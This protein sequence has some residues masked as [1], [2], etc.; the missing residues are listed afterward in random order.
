MGPNWHL[1]SA[2]QMLWVR[3]DSQPGCPCFWGRRNAKRECPGLH[4]GCPTGSPRELYLLE[5][6]P[7]L[8][9]CTSPARALPRWA[10]AFLSVRWA[11]C[12]PF[13][14][15]QITGEGRHGHPAMQEGPRVRKVP[16]CSFHRCLQRGRA[17]AKVAHRVR[18]YLAKTLRGS[19]PGE[20]SKSNVLD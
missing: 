15:C 20:E 13:L 19:C 5:T 7:S 10:S 4:G 11:W 16:G 14:S 8:E 3:S 1:E 6:V 18:T 12:P 17:L 9:P 2:L